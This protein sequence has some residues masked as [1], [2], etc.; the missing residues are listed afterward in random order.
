MNTEVEEQNEAITV[1]LHN[2]NIKWEREKNINESKVH[3]NLIDQ[4]DKKKLT[5]RSN[6]Q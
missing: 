5:Q 3:Y 1:E 6:R 4:R 2:K